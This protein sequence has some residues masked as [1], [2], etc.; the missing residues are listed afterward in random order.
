MTLH[1]FGWDHLI[2]FSGQY[3]QPK[4][5][6]CVRLEKGG[7]VETPIEWRK[8]FNY[9][10]LSPNGVPLK[11]SCWT[12]NLWRVGCVFSQTERVNVGEESLDRLSP[13]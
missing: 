8:F 13:S 1:N 9:W 7:V 11:D 5:R 4:T 3:K 12:L 6:G 10:I 2:E